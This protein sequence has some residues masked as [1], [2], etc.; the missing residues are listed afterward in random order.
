MCPTFDGQYNGLNTRMYWEKKNQLGINK[1]ILGIL[2]KRDERAWTSSSFSP[3]PVRVCRAT[4]L[5]AATI[6]PSVS[7]HCGR[8]RQS[9]VCARRDRSS[10]IFPV[11]V[12]FEHRIFSSIRK[13]RT[14]VW[15]LCLVVM[16]GAVACVAVNNQRSP[17]LKG[18]NGFTRYVINVIS[19]RRQWGKQ[20]FF[21]G[22]RG[23]KGRSVKIFK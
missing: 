15:W 6:F 23:R 1:S 7:H 4:G 3:S 17:V 8:P 18:R 13:H 10:V 22:W 19:S 9:I 2:K 5:G 14:R 12:K 20:T 21:L 16:F 11:L